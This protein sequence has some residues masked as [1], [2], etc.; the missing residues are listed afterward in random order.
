MCNTSISEEIIF[1]NWKWL[2]WFFIFFIFNNEIITIFEV[3]SKSWFKTNIRVILNWWMHNFT[4]VYLLHL[5]IPDLD[6]NAWNWLVAR[7][8][9]EMTMNLCVIEI[10]S[11]YILE[12]RW[13]SKMDVLSLQSL[14]FWSS[15]KIGIILMLP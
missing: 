6:K 9:Q 15:M 5:E 12:M 11:I 8:F 1:C 4:N 13:F 2:S 14:C 3:K 7:R 10:R